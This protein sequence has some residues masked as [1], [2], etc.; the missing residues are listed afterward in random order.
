MDITKKFIFF[1]TLLE[2]TISCL[3]FTYFS[4]AL[5]EQI[6]E[7]YLGFTR[8]V[9]PDTFIYLNIIDSVNP[10]NSILFAGIK[11]SIIP[12]FLWFI[13]HSNWYFAILL[14]SIILF[15][16]LNYFRKIAS[17]FRVGEQKTKIMMT[18]LALLPS[19]ILYSIGALKE[20][21]T[22]A[23]SL[24]FIYC[25]MKEKRF[26]WMMFF[27][28]LVLCRYQMGIALFIFFIADRYR[29]S[30]FKVAF[31]ILL[32]ISIAY[33]FMFNL[34]VFQSDATDL[35]REMNQTAST[36]GGSIEIMRNSIPGLSAL[37]IFFRVF[38]S[39]FEPLF[40]FLRAPTFIEDGFISLTL[41][42]H[43]ISLCIIIRFWILALRRF[44]YSVFIKKS[45]N[46][47]L[48]LMRLYTFCFVSIIPIAGF[49][50]IQHR[51]LYPFIP[52]IMLIAVTNLKNSKIE[53]D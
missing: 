9:I 7:N 42:A 8:I 1:I 11:N 48:N 18:I 6:W 26:C 10:I 52:I 30:S 32:S 21:P 14:N 17:I 22:L 53:V 23:F 16:G 50:F 43:F 34:G 40:T 49:S 36:L 2:F 13:A 3:Y 15:W 47:N 28:L 46:I 29:E 19:T 38:Q 4:N 27:F 24:G 5:H 25:Y 31:I 37:A 41:F 45:D 39:I 33:P 35:Y 44:Y 51:Y 20:I 12:S